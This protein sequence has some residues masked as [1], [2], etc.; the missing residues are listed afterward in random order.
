V[1]RHS[2]PPNPSSVFETTAWVIVAATMLVMPLVIMRPALDMFRTPKDVF[3]LTMSLLVFAWTAAGALFREDLARMVRIP[4]FPLLIGAAAVVWTAITTL[5][6]RQPEVS[7]FK[8]L[9]V[10]G[11]A[12][13]C[14]AACWAGRGRGLA[15]IGVVLLPAAINAVV[16]GLQSFGVRSAVISA[17][18]DSQRRL[19]T[20]GL[21]GNPND[22]G[23]Y[24]V[25]PMIA[26]IAAAF[27]WPRFRIPLAAVALLLGGGVVASQSVTPVIA[28]IAGISAMMLLPRRRT[29]RRAG[30]AMLLLIIATTGL[31]P[32]SRARIQQL[33]E[34]ARSG[35]LS[36]A[37]SFRVPAFAAATQMFLERPFVGVGPGVFS[38]RYLSYKI[39][40]DEAHPDWIRVNNQNFAE[41]H[42]DHLQILSETGI[43]GYA[44][45]L[46]ALIGLARQSFAAAPDDES[47]ARFVQGFAFPAAA[48]FFVL[49]LAH[50]PLQLTSNTVPA[51]YLAALCF[52]WVPE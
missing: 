42:N 5:T 8:P 49:A 16:A 27:A 12:A 25:L 48:A 15:A 51:T 39:A 34:N 10:F 40:L 33:V 26:A 47:R 50:F 2:S 1:D 20:T 46:I 43:L 37:T 11:V 52:A 23:G 18:P 22:L 4:R 31:H 36:D 6:S 3:F 13:F 32:G 14:L 9:T 21:I 17:G 38:T 45:F 44:L 19:L 24:F 28:S 35:R 41:V 30:I 7:Y 29:L